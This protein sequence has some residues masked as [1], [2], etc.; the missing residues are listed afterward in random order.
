MATIG[1]KVKLEDT[2]L[3]PVMILLRKT[4]GV[5]G[6]EIEMDSLAPPAPKLPGHKKMRDVALDQFGLGEPLTIDQMAAVLG[7]KSRAHGA[8]NHLSK[9]GLV[10]S[11][12]PRGTWMLTAKGRHALGL[13]SQKLLPSP[14]K[15]A[16]KAKPAKAV[17]AKAKTNGHAAPV[18]RG[19]GKPGET[20]GVLRSILTKH[21]ALTRRAIGDKM[22]EAGLAKTV[23][24]G[25]M[26]R[27][28]K[29]KMIRQRDDQLYELVP[30]EA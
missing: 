20:A 4:P 18:G 8:L 26:D 23:L 29:S 14:A 7:N 30:S 13:P 11:V 2:A 1:L 6:W 5:I 12:A 28:R 17:K 15:K 24:S 9:F 19:R 16:A 21:G 22:V 3:G 25:A 10:R 27:A